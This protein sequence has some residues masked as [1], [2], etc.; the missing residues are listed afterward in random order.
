MKKSTEKKVVLN[1]IGAT[2]KEALYNKLL[3][4][5]DLFESGKRLV[6]VYT[7]TVTGDPDLN[8][9]CER[10]S[11]AIR[12]SGG[13]AVFVGIKAINGQFVDGYP[14]WVDKDVNSVSIIQ[15]NSLKWCL[16]KDMIAQLGYSP[17]TDK[18]MRVIKVE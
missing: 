7:Y 16:L 2:E 18:N 8:K 10:I 6:S 9:L 1:V 3:H 14:T 5:A 11:D 15:A 12:G 17:T 4:S 13:Y